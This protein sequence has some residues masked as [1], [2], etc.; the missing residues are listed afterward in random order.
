MELIKIIIAQTGE[1]LLVDGLLM[2]RKKLSLAFE[3][4]HQRARLSLV[5]REESKL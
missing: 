3:P 2:S 5:G 1:V 4:G